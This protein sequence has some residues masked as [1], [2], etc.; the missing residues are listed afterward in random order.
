MMKDDVT[1]SLVL[2]S[3]CSS[4]HL[5]L[6]TTC[7]HPL[8]CD[9]TG[10]MG[11]KVT[12][13]V[14]R[15]LICNHKLNILKHRFDIRKEYFMKRWWW[16]QTKIFHS[17]LQSQHLGII[18]WR[19]CTVNVQSSGCRVAHVTYGKWIVRSFV[20]LPAKWR[21]VI[22]LCV[23]AL[24]ISRTL[25][26]S[27]G[28]ERELWNNTDDEWLAAGATWM[29]CYGTGDTEIICQVYVDRSLKTWQRSDLLAVT[30]SPMQVREETWREKKLLYGNT[31]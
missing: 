30:S 11:S 2:F 31:D 16:I 21:A 12:E 4:R 5:A 10:S 3:S 18:L 15:V 9:R 24:R 23:D 6:P 26:R 7:C 25:D 28:T 13:C 8:W 29:W 1:R 14:T 22:G 19:D 17:M 27:R 20:L